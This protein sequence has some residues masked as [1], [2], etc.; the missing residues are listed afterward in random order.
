[1]RRKTPL[2]RPLSPRVESR[3]CDVRTSHVVSPTHREML[4]ATCGFHLT[5]LSDIIRAEC[6]HRVYAAASRAPVDIRATTHR[7]FLPC[8]SRHARALAAYIRGGKKS[9]LRIT[10]ILS[11]SYAGDFIFLE[12][13]ETRRV[14]RTFEIRGENGFPAS[15][16]GAECF[17]AELRAH[18]SSRSFAKR[19]LFAEG[20]N[21][22]EMRLKAFYDTR[23]KTERHDDV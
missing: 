15:P 1:M 22:Y 2:V 18:L 23:I 10:V 12:T 11:P 4:S 14:G 8:Y 20:S 9:A 5:P 6:I 21:V 16:A 3:D 19:S 13:G 7:A 17:L